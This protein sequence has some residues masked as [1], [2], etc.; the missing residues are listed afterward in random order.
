LS[1]EDSLV[2]RLEKPRSSATAQGFN[3]IKEKTMDF[4]RFVQDRGDINKSGKR[5]GLALPGGG[6]DVVFD[7]VIGKT[8]HRNF[9]ERDLIEMPFG[10]RLISLNGELIE[11][12]K[13]LST[14]LRRYDFGSHLPLIVEQDGAEDHVDVITVIPVRDETPDEAVIREFESETGHGVSIVPPKNGMAFYPHDPEYYR[15]GVWRESKYGE[16][17]VE[18]NND[19]LGNGLKHYLYTFHLE[20]SGIAENGNGAN[21]NGNGVKKIREVDEIS[22]VLKIATDILLKKIYTEDLSVRYNNREG[23]PEG[24]YPIHALRAMYCLWIL[25]V[26]YADNLPDIYNSDLGAA[27]FKT[28]RAFLPEEVDGAIV[29]GKF[30]FT[31][32]EEVPAELPG[33]AL[34][35]GRDDS[36]DAWEK[37]LGV[38]AS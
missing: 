6:V 35:A 17:M 22:G 25:K 27:Q 33:P 1:N 7:A 23:N 29:G 12:K 15:S 20:E 13:N 26:P 37:W 28:L 4:F 14:L 34:L 38:G 11:N 10:F 32:E 3:W 18:I 2:K 19:Y 21:G 24:F 36:K 5:K 16:I 9:I 8:V 31:E 30:D